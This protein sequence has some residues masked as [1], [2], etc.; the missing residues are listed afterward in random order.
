[1]AKLRYSDLELRIEATSTES[2]KRY[3][4]RVLNSP[5]GEA[6]HRFVLPF[7][8][9]RLENL[10]LKLSGGRRTNRRIHSTEMQ[11]ARDFGGQLFEAVF[12]DEVLA[13]LR[14]S[15]RLADQ[16]DRGL[17]LKLRLQ[18]VSELADLPWEFLHDAKMDCFFAQSNRT[19]IVRYIELPQPVRPLEVALPLRVSV[20]VSSPRDAAYAG[21]DT[22]RE[23]KLLEQALKPLV[24]QG[25]VE[26]AFL[27]RATLSALQSNLRKT[28]HHIFHFIGHGGFDNRTQEGVLVF[29]DDEQRAQW[30]GAQRLGTLLHDHRSLRLAVLN[31]CEGARNSTTDPF[32]GVATTLV[33]Q[34]LPAVVA[35]QFEI[36]DSAAIAFAG[37]FY[38]SLT[39]GYPVDA[40]VAEARKAIYAQPND[41]EWGTP[42]LYLRAAD[43][44]IFDVQA[45]APPAGA[46]GIEGNQR[47]NPR[48]K[49]ALADAALKPRPAKPPRKRVPTETVMPVIFR[50]ERRLKELP[51]RSVIPLDGTGTVRFAS[52]SADAE[53]GVFLIQDRTV[54]ARRIDGGELLWSDV[55]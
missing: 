21:L 25:K 12:G 18:D 45:A 2:G 30:A 36:S 19:P 10:V 31:S 24:D 11:A 1:M 43:G 22:K 41:V 6:E 35:M 52:L 14:S 4:A 40:A 37:E 51:A 16:D 7:S 54:E 42:V 34:G 44:Q 39:D 26:V 20:M 23:R 46:A 5:A 55:E 49:S 53:I 50:K 29:E 32:A 48:A 8:A 38:S 27:P 17:R 15:L 3:L 13:C 47:R 9:E 33:R 28:E